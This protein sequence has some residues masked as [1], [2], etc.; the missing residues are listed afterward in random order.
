MERR[1]IKFNLVGA[2]C[3][4]ILIIA[5][6]IGLIIGIPKLIN[7]GKN[8]KNEVQEIKQ[9]NE[10]KEEVKEIDESQ[11]YV[12]KIKY[13]DGSET[14]SIMKY[15]KSDLGY[16]M[17]YDCHLF[18]PEKNVENSDD[19]L[20]LFSNTILIT[21]EKCNEKFEDAE[22]FMH[23]ER[24]RLEKEY[25]SAI[26]NTNQ[27]TNTQNNIIDQ[28]EF[29]VEPIQIN[30]ATGI[31]SIFTTTDGAEYIYCIKINDEEYYKIKVNCSAVF[32]AEQIPII[33]YMI[34]TF[35][36]IKK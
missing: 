26:R 14:E 29:K 2:I 4:L 6:V 30:D 24:E 11:E 27:S 16:A 35:E 5:L 31:K 8:N 15:C 36:I 3:I 12:E 32:K 23:M 21:V 20:S 34:N 22:K 1:V 25:I 17:K 18:Y 13:P 7:Q 10:E 9:S 33:E 19:Y 28:S